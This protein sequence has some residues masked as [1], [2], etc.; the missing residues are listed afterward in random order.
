MAHFELVGKDGPERG[1]QG[2]WRG[3]RRRQRRRRTWSTAASTAWS[4]SPPTPTR[5]RSRTA[6]RKL[7]LQ[8]GSNVTKGLGAG[9]NPEVGRQAALEDRERIMDALEGSDMVF[10]TAGMGGGTGTGAAPVV[11]QTREGDGH[12]HRR[13]RDQAVPVRGPPPHAGG[14]QGHRRARPSTCDSLITIPNE[15]LITVLGRNATMIQAFRAANDVLLGAVQGIADLII[16]PGLINVDFADVRTVMSE[17]GLAMM[18]T[19][20]ARGDDRAQAAAESAIQ[21]PLLDDVNLSGANGI[22]VNITAGPDFTMA[23]F[24]EVGRTIENFASEDATVVI[25][26]VLDPDM[27]D[28]V[29]V[30][31]VATGL[32]RAVSRQAL[33][34]RGRQQVAARAMVRSPI[35]LVRNATTGQPDFDAMANL[36][37]PVVPNFA[38]SLRAGTRPQRAG[39]GRLR[40]RQQL[41]DIPAFLRRAGGLSRRSTSSNAGACAGPARGV[42]RSA[43]PCVGRPVSDGAARCFPRAFSGS[44]ATFA[45]AAPRAPPASRFPPPPARGSNAT[46]MLPQRTL[47]NVIRATGVGL[48]SGEKV[49]LTLRPAA[50]DTGIVFRRVDL[51]PGRGDPR[52]RANVVTDTMLCTGLSREGGKVMTIEH[53]MSAFAGLGIDNA[54]VDL[55]APEVPIMDGSAGPFVFLLQ[56]A[57]IEEQTAPKRFIRIRKP[58]EVRDGDKIARFEPHDGFRIGFTVDF[59]HPA[60]P[61]RSRAPRSTSPTSYVKEV[62]RAPAPSA[63]CATWS[64]CASA[65]SASAARWTTPSC[66]TSSAC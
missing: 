22:L 35:K 17:M 39:G 49:Y 19:G 43:E 1:D 3:R 23:E 45:A 26:T 21:N 12:P 20:S 63:S 62:S 7:Q 25:G 32:N 16:R 14:A 60:I 41:L 40:Q 51:E 59:D 44:R 24:D 65:T 53:L 5:R 31:V 55:S 58:V 13:R 4:S 61:A 47:K 54:Y 42:L 8:L 6:A 66:S 36:S 52:R 28:E 38:G 37:E 57:G 33:P 64:S 34:S 27:Q 30:T 2:D 9:A 15:K 10:I 18:G 50:V 11:A 46:P 56:S 48:H 29:K